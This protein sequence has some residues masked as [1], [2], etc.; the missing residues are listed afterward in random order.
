MNPRLKGNRTVRMARE[1]L[2][3]HGW[4]S[5]T[6]EK[7]GKYLK[8]RDL[9]SLY[10]IISLKPGY[11]PLFIQVKTN[12]PAAQ[13]PLQLFSDRYGVHGLCMTWY[14]RKG[15]VFH[16]YVPGKRVIRED[17]RGTKCLKI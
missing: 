6:V 10:D 13:K 17:Y 14:S 11:S 12:V 5:D 3:F 2:H 15:W 16:R 7:S 8:N 9:F 1:L 4:L